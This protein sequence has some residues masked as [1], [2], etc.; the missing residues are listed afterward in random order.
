M[1][2]GFLSLREYLDDCKE[3]LLEGCLVC[4]KC[5]TACPVIPWTELKDINP[6]ELQEK[7]LAF[8]R[9]GQF[10]Q[11]IYDQAY[12]CE[13]CDICYRAC[14]KGLHSHTVVEVMKARLKNNGKE[15][16]ESMKRSLPRNDKYSFPNIAANLQLKPSETRWLTHIPDN[17]DHKEI[18]FFLGCYVHASPSKIF[19][20]ID[21][22]ER[23]GVDFITLGGGAEACCGSVFAHAGEVDE[24]DRLA[25]KLT[26]NL[27]AFRPSTVVFWCH[28]CAMRF[29]KTNSKFVPH[30]FHVSHITQFLCEN[31][32][33][34]EFSKS[35]KE[36]V[37]LQDSCHMG[38]GLS[39]YDS[40]RKIL[41]TIPGV[42]L[43]EM[44]NSREFSGNCG[45]ILSISRPEVGG[46][47]IE[48]QMKEAQETGSDVLLNLCGACDRSFSRREANYPFRVTDLVTFLG[49]AMG[50]EYEDKMKKYRSYNDLERVLMEARE[51]FETNGFTMEEIRGFLPRFL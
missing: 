10:Y 49:K 30:S 16:P 51:C 47:L 4:G 36:K 35:L 19:T 11:E 25:R 6:K 29:K 41:Q 38:R 21:I 7:R 13:G 9:N 20:A 42:E 3:K 23:M 5:M 33:K 17:P 2:E 12:Y 37:T 34:V 43:V 8:L 44:K 15:A 26:E 50:I 18:V 48:R 32:D 1:K 40:P 31:L 27:E 45:G 39:D 24:A 14:P 22:L 46:K 28:G